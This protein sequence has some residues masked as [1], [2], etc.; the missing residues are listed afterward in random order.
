MRGHFGSQSLCSLSIA[1]RPQPTRVFR[2]D[3]ASRLD[4]I[5]LIAALFERDVTNGRA[6]HAERGTALPSVRRRRQSQL[7]SRTVAR[8]AAA[9]AAARQVGASVQHVVVHPRMLSALR[10]TTGFAADLITVL[11]LGFAATAVLVIAMVLAAP[12]A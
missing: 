3:A 1:M 11:A 12:P 2:T 7:L 4:D 6:I 9:T 5:E 8:S 10:A